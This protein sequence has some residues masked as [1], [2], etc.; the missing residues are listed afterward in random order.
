MREAYLE[1]NLPLFKTDG[2][3]EANL[4]VAGRGTSY[5]TAG[6]AKTWKI[7]RAEQDELA[8]LSHVNA[9]KA[10]ARGFF[11][12]LV[13]GEYQGLPYMVLE[14][15]EG[16]TLSQVLE[17]KPEGGAYISCWVSGSMIRTQGK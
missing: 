16:K 4:N 3:G 14:Y 7:G 1:V 10:W 11:S 12:D 9:G 15:L 5:S 8:N 17:T 6:N 13:V 2:L